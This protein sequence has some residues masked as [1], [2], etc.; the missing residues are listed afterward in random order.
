MIRESTDHAG[1]TAGVSSPRTVASFPTYREAERAVDH[2]ADRGFAVERVAIVG[3]GLHFVEQVT[4]RLGWGKA[5][6]RGAL[7][8]AIVG[9]LVGWLFGLFDWFDPIVSAFWLA[10]DGLWFGALVGL[11]MGLTLY[12]F[13]AGRRDFTSFGSMQADRYDVVVD[14]SVADE[15]ARLLGELT[16]QPGTSPQRPSEPPP[17]PSS[18]VRER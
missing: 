9:V 18:A 1:G 6:L 8:G 14:A 15:A 16:G 2:M 13:T 5:A 4:G 11:A 7:T 3:H 17:P 10:L 12:A